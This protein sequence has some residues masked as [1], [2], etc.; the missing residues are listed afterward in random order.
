MS[1]MTRHERCLA[2]IEG[3]Q[4]DRPPYYIPA[5]ACEV[6]S[7][8]LGR[9]VH[10]G[11]G[12]LH[13]AE[14]CALVRGPD[15]HAEFVNH[16]FEGL[17][18]LGEA[19]DLDVYR[20]PWRQTVTPTKQI[21]ETSFLFGDPDG[22]HEIHAYMPET[23]D[24][25]VARRVE[26]NPVDPIEALRIQ[27]EAGEERLADGAMDGVELDP[28]YQRICREHGQAFFIPCNGGEITLGY[29]EEIFMATLTDP[30]LLR[31]HLM[32]QAE[33]GLALGRALARSPYPKVILGGGDM[34]GNEGPFFSPETFRQ[35]HMPAIRHLAHGLAA[36]GI[37]YV[38]RTDGNLW[39]V[40]DMLFKD[41]A[42]QGYG[43][44][45][46][47]AG[48]TTARVREAYPDLVLWNN[49]SSPD[50]RFQSADWV[51]EESARCI[52]ESG[53]TR[54]FHGCSNALIMGTP[55][56]NVRALFGG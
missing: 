49:V 30:D 20:M 2:T 4:V 28:D 25:G 14:T 21:D 17:A 56:E 37:H 50:L 10:S 36:M 19:L 55:V 9:P 33:R 7:R 51:R 42:C 32:L 13:Y 12:S 35:V 24:F 16:L 1:D 53:G 41:A 45:D 26:T 27:V 54:Y 48:M 52:A 29:T 18:E 22:D 46:R 5:I 3:R 23:G 40:M 31:R 43:E 34:A 38:W 39:S 47:D 15:A 11:T 6:S 8:V 44:V